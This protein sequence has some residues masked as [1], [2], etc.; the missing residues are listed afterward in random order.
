MELAPDG[1]FSRQVARELNKVGFRGGALQ[2]LET[3][4][5]AS[6]WLVGWFFLPSTIWDRCEELAEVL[7]AMPQ[8]SV[9]ES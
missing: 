8:S 5:A 1:Q 3:N 6:C 7:L 2:S 4:T 9:D